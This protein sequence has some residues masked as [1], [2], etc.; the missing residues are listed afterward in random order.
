MKEENLHK[1]ICSYI[2]LQYP[3]VIFNTDLSGI[4]LT[5]GQA[6]KLKSLRSSRAFPDLFVYEPRGCFKG[7]FAEIKRENP[8]KKNGMLK[9]DDH[10]E[11]QAEMM[12]KLYERGYYGGF[13][14]DF[15]QFKM[16]F[17]FYITL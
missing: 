4:K 11:A 5:M 9:A 3:Q 12:L 17:D 1:Q 15:E 10:L 6:V 13:Y 2:K 16:A 14:W 8:Y 7:F